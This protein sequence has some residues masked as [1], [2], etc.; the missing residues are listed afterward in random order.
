M[1]LRT[2]LSLPLVLLALTAAQ[3]QQYPEKPIRLLAPF[4]AGGLSDLLARALGTRLT[5]SMGQPVIIENRPGGGTTIA[6]EIVAKA[7]PDGYTLFLQDISAHAINAT[8]FPKLPYDSVKDFTQVAL[9]ASSPLMLVV[10][11]GFPASNLRDLIALGKAR[12][13]EFAYASPGNGTLPHLVTEAF[14]KKAGVNF[15]HVPYK[16]GTAVALI[17]GQVALTFSI[18]PPA[19]T[20]L[21]AGKF[22]A[23]GVTS[24]KR[25]GVA[26][27]VPTMAEA[28]LPNFEFVI[29]SGVLGPA[30]IARRVVDKLNS[31]IAKAVASPEMNTTLVAIGAEPASVTP[32]QFTNY[33][34]A[35]IDKL[36]RVV[37]ETG[38]KVD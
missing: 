22:V 1:W 28:G 23:M 26:P 5:A 9:V 19:V 14:K 4:P 33:L 7:A 17:S 25:S 3:A 2:T 8:L 37:K 18:M 27:A 38:A 35:E 6:S 31:E 10:L 36:G 16:G 29:Y 20:N 15:L 24:A 21:K 30:G 32:E 11:A 13:G 12:P 34:I